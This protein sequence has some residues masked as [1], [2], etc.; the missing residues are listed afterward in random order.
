MKTLNDYAIYSIHGDDG[1]AGDCF[2]LALHDHFGQPLRVSGNGIVDLKAKVSATVKTYN[3]VEVKTGA[4]QIP[5]NLKGNSYVVY[6]PVVDLSL[7]L[8]KQEAFVVKRA[9]F[10]KCLQEA[11]CYRVSKRTTAGTST[12]AIQTFWNRKL[13]KPHGRKL[14]YLLDALYASGCQTLEEWLEET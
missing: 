7:P 8:H 13:N 14:S 10:I 1:L 2:E 3:K 6:C 9:V 12:E 4:G 5:N 11:E